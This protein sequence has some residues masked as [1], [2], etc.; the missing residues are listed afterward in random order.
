MDENHLDNKS[1]V[2]DDV[3]WVLSKKSNLLIPQH[4]N[5]RR[6]LFKIPFDWLNLI[7]VLLI[8]FVVTVI[9]LYATQQITQQQAQSS[10]R[11]HQ[12]DIQIAQDQQREATLETYIS[13]MQGLLL[14][15]NLRNSKP[16]DEVRSI[17][18]ARTITALQQ[19]NNDNDR[20]TSLVLF[21]YQ[22]HLIN[23]SSSNSDQVNPI[24]SLASADLSNM[25]FHNK[26]ASNTGG[27]VEVDNV[28]PSTDAAAILL[29][30]ICNDARST[31]A[32]IDLSGTNLENADFLCI[33]LTNADFSGSDLTG[34]NLQ[35]DLDNAN[36][37]NSLLF[38]ANLNGTSLIN[39]NLKFANFCTAL[40]NGSSSNCANISSADCRDANLTASDFNQDTKSKGTFLKG[41]RMPDGSIHP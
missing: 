21:L 24:I 22:A 5:Q 40:A 36:L 38:N 25:N 8:P 1:V 27:V 11:Q 13:N 30:S 28:N 37:S 6:K 39:A 33:N 17:A 20:K 9:G 12:T 4:K 16:G 41:A 23:V 26:L 3:T 31:L 14:N 32:G 19:L 10:E 35:G 2:T 18:Q 15:Y 29:K 34:A 7:G